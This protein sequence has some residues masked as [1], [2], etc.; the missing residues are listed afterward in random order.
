MVMSTL[1]GASTLSLSALFT[2]PSA[3]ELF[4]ISRLPRTLALILTGGSMSIAGLLMQ[5]LTQN[6]FVEPTTAGTIPAASLGFLLALIY[7]PD[8]N[9]LVKMV[10]SCLFALLGTLLF[11]A[12]LQKMSLKSTLMVP[13]VGMMLGAVISAITTFI[14]IRYD[15]LQS[16][17]S[18]RTGDFSMILRGRYEL[19]WFIL[20]LSGIIYLT[21]ARFTLVGLG[22]ELAINAGLNYRLVLLYG[23][24]MVAMISGVTVVVVGTLP[25]IGLIVPN[26]ISLMMGDNLRK[27]IPW[28]FF[29]GSGLVLLCD[30]IGRLIRYPFE[31]PVGTI[32]GIVGALVFLFLVVKQNTYAK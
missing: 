14:A 25:F 22:R 13:I 10:G 27:S 15:L 17:I 30:I 26:I 21:A 32:L 28:I 4:L 31:I 1:V 9:L 8:A 16:L 12:I 19:L 29:S 11:L 2:D 23:L 24:V 6:K 3:R 7:F 5:M 18:W 20:G